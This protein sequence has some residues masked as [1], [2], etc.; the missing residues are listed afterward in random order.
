MP[1]PFDLILEPLIAARRSV[2]VDQSA[3]GRPAVLRNLLVG[4]LEHLV[5]RLS[6][7]HR[8]LSGVADAVVRV[9]VHLLKVFPNDP[10]AE[11]VKGVDGGGRQNLHLLDQPVHPLPILRVR[12]PQALGE[13]RGQP[14]LHFSG[15]R[16]GEGQ[17]QQG[18]DGDL[19]VDDHPPDALD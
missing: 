7:E 5:L 9:H 6:V 16:P 18:I 2:T 17:N 14:L 19:F 8:K 1:Q 15:C 11:G 3:E 10:G 4:R 12:L 13:R